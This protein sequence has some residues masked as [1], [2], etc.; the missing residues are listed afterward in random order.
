[1]KSYF[2]FLWVGI[3]DSYSLMAMGMGILG[4]TIAGTIN[5]NLSFD[6]YLFCIGSIF[7]ILLLSITLSFI[8]LKAKGRIK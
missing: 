1:M 3:N 7:V 8:I 5:H 4:Y 2:K 6:G